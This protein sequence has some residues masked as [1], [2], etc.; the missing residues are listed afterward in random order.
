MLDL[1]LVGVCHVS[2]LYPNVKYK[3]DLLERT[4]GMSCRR[5]V[6]DLGSGSLYGSVG[7]RSRLA[8]L[9]LLFRITFGTLAVFLKTLSARPDR[10][11]LAYPSLPL[12][13]LFCLLPCRWRP[14]L[15]V[16]AFISLYD[17]IV[18]DRGLYAAGS[19]VA[20]LLYYVE[21][22]TF[23]CAE[24]VIVDTA[25][26]GAYYA[27]LFD[28]SP[29]KFVDV[30][31]CVPPLV[32]SQ[33]V[34]GSA[35]EPGFTCLFVGSLVPL[36]GIEF[37]L[38]AARSLKEYRHIRFVIIGDGQDGRKVEAF[39]REHGDC[40]LE[41]KRG[42]FPT[43]YLVER[44]CSADLCLGIFGES[45]KAQRVLPYK[46]YY[47]AALG[48]PFLTRSTDCL[49]R[50]CSGELESSFLCACSVGEAGSLA[51]HILEL[52]GNLARLDRLGIVSRR[53]F[54]REL[55][56]PAIADKLRAVLQQA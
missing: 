44:I 12:M 32:P 49:R 14:R 21:R 43:E 2:D 54:D 36:H 5:I 37:I 18:V 56:D 51:S 47:Y 15:F 52:S 17:T 3:L 26:N 4:A 11:Y 29:E 6:H 1:A 23:A 25:E 16:D 50:V 8:S 39:L 20:R 28:L 22:R 40:N 35:G 31:L 34:R 41:W 33:E 53:L 42:L 24:R 27:A 46:I 7:K 30:A 19:L 38:E 9:R 45:G 13:L 48:K 55:S 10:V